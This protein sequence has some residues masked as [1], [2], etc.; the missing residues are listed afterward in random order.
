MKSFIV[1]L[2]MIFLCSAQTF[3]QQTISFE[4]GTVNGF[5]NGSS[6]TGIAASTTFAR[7][8]TYSVTAKSS[9]A[10]SSVRYFKNTFTTVTGTNYHCIC[11]IRAGDAATK[12]AMSIDGSTPTPA[13][14]TPTTFTRYTATNT[15]QKDIRVAMVNSSV[16]DNI[17]VDD[18]VYYTGSSTTTDIL[19]PN[20]P[21]TTGSSGSNSGGHGLLTWTSGGDNTGT[22][23]TGVQATMILQYTGTGTPSAGPT[24]NNQASYAVNDVISTNWKVINVSAAA[25]GTNVDAGAI[26]STTYYA[27]YHRDLAYNW[28]AAPSSNTTGLITVTVVTSTN[29]YNAANSD[30]TDVNNWWSNTN[31]TSGTH[32]SNFTANNQLF[33]ITHTGSTMS[34][35]WTVSGT[36]SK[37]ILGDGS[38]TNSFSIPSGSALTG[39]I[40]VT[41]AATLNIA[42]T[43][44]PTLGTLGTSSTVA[45]TNGSSAQ[46]ASATAYGNLTIA[47]GTGTVSLSAATTVAANLTITSGTL[48]VTGSNY[49]LSVAGN[50]SNSGT[51]TPGSGTVTFNGTTQA[52]SG[53]STTSFSGITINTGST[54]TGPSAGTINVAGN[55][56]NNGAFTHNGCTVNFNGTT[57]ISGSATNSFNNLSIASSSTLTGPSTATINVAGNWSNSGTFTHNSGTV[58]LNS[59]TNPS[60]Q[61][62]SGSTTFNNLTTGNTGVTTAFGTSTTTIAGNFSVGGGTMDGGTSTIIFTGASKSL[63]GSTAKNF[64]NLQ[65][66]NGASLTQTAGTSVTVSNSYTNNGNGSFTQDATRTITFKTASPFSLSGTGTSTFGN[67][68]IA[69]AITVNA[70]SHNFTVLGTIDF[71]NA[72]GVFNGG[73]GTVTFSG[74]SAAIGNGSNGTF[75]FNNIAIASSSTLSNALNKN[76]NI[77]GNW[78]DNGTYTKGTETITFNGSSNQNIVTGE[79]FNNVI[80]NNAAGITLSGSSTSVSVAGTLTLTGGNVTLGSNNLILA[81][82]NAVAGTPASSNHIV[83][84][85]TGF[86]QSVYSTG[87]YT[88]PV[89]FDAGD[90]NPVIITN[91]SASSQTYTARAASASVVTTSLTDGLKAAWSIGGITTSSSQLAFPWNSGSDVAGS[92]PTSGVAY[93]SSGTSS[94]AQ[95]GGS[96]SGGPTNYTTTY[97]PVSTSSSSNYW[98]VGSS[99]CTAPTTIYSVTGG[100]AYCTG[101]TVAIGLSGSQSGVSYQ[102]FNGASSVGSPVSGTG[103]AIS[104]GTLAY[105]A[106]TYTVKSTTSGGYCAVAM[107]G[108]PSSVSVSVNSN[109]TAAITSSSTSIIS[110]ANTTIS[111]TISATNPFTLTLSD[112]STVTTQSS[113]TWSKTV[114]PITT[115]TYTLSSLTDATACSTGTLSGSVTVTVVQAPTAGSTIVTGST[116]SSQTVLTLTLPPSNGGSSRIIIGKKAASTGFTPSSGTSYAAQTSTTQ[117]FTTATAA[118]AGGDVII[119]NGTGSGPVTVTGL[120]ASSTYAFTV[121]EYNGTGTASNYYTAASGN[122]ATAITGAGGTTAVF[123][124]DYESSSFSSPTLTSN[125]A[126]L[127]PA[128]TNITYTASA[129]SGKETP[130]ILSAGGSNAFQII[131]GSS[132]STTTASLTSNINQYQSPFNTKLALNTGTITWTFN[133]SALKSSN[134]SATWA[135]NNNQATVLC[136]DATFSVSAGNGY[137]LILGG[138]TNKTVQLVRF[139][140]GLG[141]TLTSIGSFTT[142]NSMTNFF[143][144]KV[145]FTPDGS[146]SGTWTVNYADNGSSAFANPTLA[147]TTT[148]IAN[149][150]EPVGT[151]YLNTTMTSF[152]YAMSHSNSSGYGCIWDNLKAVVSGV[153]SCTTPAAFVAGGGGSYC[154]SGSGVSVTLSGSETGTSY[155]LYNGAT[156]VGSSV[157]GTGSAI[158][159]NNVT[160]SSGTTTYTVKG[161]STCGTTTMAGSAAVTVNANP[162]ITSAT[163]GSNSYG[164][165]ATYQITA[166]NTPTGYSTSTLPSG[167]SLNSSTGLISIANTAAVGTYNITITASNANSCSG[168]TTLVYTIVPGTTT[169]KS[170]NSTSDWSTS[171]NWTNGVPSTSVDASIPAGNTP[172]PALTTNITVGNLTFGTAATLTIGANTLTINGTISG[173]GTFT[174]SSVSNLVLGNSNLNP[175]LNFTSGADTLFNLTLNDNATATLGSTLK[176]AARTNGTSAKLTVGNSSILNTADG[177]TLISDNYNTAAVGP[178]G[179]NGSITG[180]VTVQRYLRSNDNTPYLDPNGNI[181]SGSA[182][183]AWRLLTAP[184]K[185]SGVQ[186]IYQA[187][188]ENGLVY[189]DGDA[190]T[191]EKGT[192]ITGPNANNGLESGINANYS[193]KAFNY[194]TQKLENVDNT[195]VAISQGSNGGSA[196]NTGYFIFIRGDRNPA[197][198]NNPNSGIVP[199]DNT[200]LSAKGI[201]QTGPQVFPLVAS[202]GISSQKYTLVG[203]PYASPIDLNSVSFSGYSG[204]IDVY[205]WDPSIG[206]VGAYVLLENEFNGSGYSGFQTNAQSNQT[207]YIQSSQAFFVLGSTNSPSVTINESS[208]VAAQ[209]NNLVFRPTGAPANPWMIA[210]LYNV[211]NDNSVNSI[212]YNQTYFNNAYSMDAVLGEDAPK[213]ANIGETF[214]VI[215]GG[216]SLFSDRRPNLREMDTVFFKLL[217]TKAQQKYQLRFFDSIPGTNLEAWLKDNYTNDSMLISLT[218][219]S[220]IYSFTSGGVDGSGHNIDSIRFSILFRPQAPVPVTFTNVKAQWMGNSNVS[221]QWNVANQLNINKYEVE[222]SA[223]GKTFSNAADITA[224]LGGATAQYNWTDNMAIKGDNY[225]RIKSIG[226]DGKVEY[227]QVMNISIGIQAPDIAIYPN[228]V[229]GNSIGLKFTNMPSGKY[230]VNVINQL[231]QIVLTDNITHAGGNATQ[232]VPVNKNITKGLYRLEIIKA[233]NIKTNINFVY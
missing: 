44:N 127:V 205:T 92:A 48:D 226:N 158:T 198:I 63:Q 55:W 172:Y 184:F 216:S 199:V 73:T 130:S 107:A 42:N 183:R 78:T 9:S 105:S 62:I 110:G 22:G 155:Q 104:F 67:V 177:L 88:F 128:S 28:S 232:T 106:G 157:S 148:S 180:N 227:S 7:T 202:S 118:G 145:V 121:Y 111:G 75:N 123:F 186:T 36:S 175:T 21:V 138:A 200:T 58:V 120:S 116:S 65:I 53:S 126:N 96:T 31:G 41:N 70:G 170:G 185:N 89:G 217:R 164:N 139:T 71:T 95:Q 1:L 82:A 171:G 97:S 72:S 187:W 223:D 220:S 47:N 43:T 91:N 23:T 207:S 137:A 35:A 20:T 147:A 25:A 213:L 176:L 27:I 219:S 221:V 94:W 122:S 166:S 204:N 193:M 152:G 86:V 59:T 125:A 124:D 195:N 132:P 203:N 113:G 188:Q 179:T 29:Y 84:N 151:S 68:S 77:A 150:A 146:G 45:Y 209:N 60:T 149:T 189:E 229:S 87:S 100:G 156:A 135:G 90:Y 182:K 201:L 208:K 159:F 192:L 24:L 136:S 54:L 102:L 233:N 2:P 196:E 10:S 66:N 30:V 46:T 191:H 49:G 141:G 230:Q 168:S 117:N 51:F 134:V 3:S 19:S 81:S 115:T 178:I 109:P 169:W 57:T 85:S 222:R 12:L 74:A 140:N 101:G 18:V 40:D 206:D 211:N 160:S 37:I 165:A 214:S 16:A 80:I 6:M 61:T 162:A 143:S 11:W 228:P 34:T 76:F 224:Q 197:T 8:G 163:T 108:S 194:S 93:Y 144:F 83:T 215:R 129:V 231:G 173:A 210:R 142:T 133:M 98:S 174:G 56:T 161:T 4:D 153:S 69:G 99:S 114:S 33:N 14:G 13:T 15:S 181:Y 167:F 218:D 112:A 212:D 119:Y 190:S 52:I 26:S 64:Y 32:P 225:Y 103:T 79:T 50:W 39:T 17:Y 131:T 154:A 38:T 5:N